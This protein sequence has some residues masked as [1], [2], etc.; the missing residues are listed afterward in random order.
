MN[1]VAASVQAGS[2]RRDRREFVKG[3]TAVIG[4]TGLFGYDIRLAVAEPPPETTRIRIV[5]DPAVCLAPQFLAEELLRLEGFSQIEYV[6][7][8]FDAR[9]HSDRHL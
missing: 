6:Q 1:L 2:V 8:A 7:G 9:V 4:A 3:L 5:L